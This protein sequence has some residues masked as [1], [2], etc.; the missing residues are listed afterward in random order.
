MHV[1]ITS[2]DA[3]LGDGVQFYTNTTY[4]CSTQLINATT[5]VLTIF[6][7]ELSLGKSAKLELAS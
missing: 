3:V 4:K 2:S 1:D 6:Y 5:S 7:F